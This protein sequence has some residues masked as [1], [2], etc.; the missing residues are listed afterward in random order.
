MSCKKFPECLGA[1]KDDGSEIAPPKEIGE[2]CPECKDDFPYDYDKHGKRNYDAD[3]DDDDDEDDEEEEDEDDEDNEPKKV[4][5]KGTGYQ[6]RR[7][8]NLG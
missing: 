5:Q 4:D 8:Y 1:R 3:S 2:A 6:S 7:F